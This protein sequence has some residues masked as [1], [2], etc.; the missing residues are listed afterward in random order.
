M[1]EEQQ[2]KLKHVLSEPAVAEIDRWIAKYPAEQRQSAVMQALMI[3]QEEHDGYLTSELMDA[4]A[5]Y[6]AMPKIQVYEV[7]TF[8]NMYD[9]KPVGRH[10]IGVCGSISCHLMGAKKI[11]QHLENKLGVQS[12]GTTADGKFTFKEVECLGACKGGPAA[13]IDKTY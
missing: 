5:E 11:I 4:V 2:Y 8:Y 7:A 3:V 10:K 9:L 12:G 13:F 1:V 6:L